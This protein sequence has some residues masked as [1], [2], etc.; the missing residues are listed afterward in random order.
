ML[1]RKSKNTLSI[2]YLFRQK[3]FGKR[4]PSLCSTV[5]REEDRLVFLPKLAPEGM[6]VQC[7]QHILH[8]RT[9]FL[10][11]LCVSGADTCAFVS[12]FKSGV[13]QQG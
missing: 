5:E 1:V 7:A 13:L 6:A 3:L 12:S 10:S 4:F 8:M 11:I 9:R 2:Y